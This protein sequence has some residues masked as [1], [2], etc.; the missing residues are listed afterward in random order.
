MLKTLHVLFVL[1]ALAVLSGCATA[2]TQINRTGVV[3]EGTIASP[4]SVLGK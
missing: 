2:E 3:E 1:G 4:D